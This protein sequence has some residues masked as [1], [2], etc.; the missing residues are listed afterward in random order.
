MTGTTTDCIRDCCPAS[1]EAMQTERA[2]LSL[3]QQ[4][5][6]RQA[7]ALT[8]H[9]QLFFFQHVSSAFPFTLPTVSGVS[10]LVMPSRYNSDFTAVESKALYYRPNL[11]GRVERG[12]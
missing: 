10:S 11:A 5:K 8:E 12:M 4:S 2:K 9:P 7:A 3:S 1:L 6:N